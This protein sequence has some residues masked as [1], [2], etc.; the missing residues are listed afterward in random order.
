M[1]V[2]LSGFGLGRTIAPQTDTA[3]VA[4]DV[5]SFELVDP[6]GAATPG[7]WR[8]SAA[9]VFFGYTHCPDVCP[10]SRGYAYGQTGAIG[11]RCAT[12]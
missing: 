3:A 8:G 10:A 5:I 11:R 4:S 6:E 9:L 7:D 12:V 2:A 1:V